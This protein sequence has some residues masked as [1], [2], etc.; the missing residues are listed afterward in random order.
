MEL[1]EITAQ[2]Y[3][4]EVC[5]RG[6]I[7]CQKKFL[8]LNAPKVD[9]VH[10]YIL[11]DEKKRLAFAIGEKNGEWKAPFSAPFAI[12]IELRGNSD[13]KYYWELFNLLK[14][15]VKSEGGK[16]ID[17]YLPPD[18]YNYSQISKIYNSLLGNGFNITY[19]EVNYSF[20]VDY[21]KRKGYE[22]CIHYNAKKNLKIAERCGLKFI[23]CTSLEEKKQAYDIIRVNRDSKGY[24][25]AMSWEQVFDTINVVEHDFFIIKNGKNGIA[26]AMVFK[27]TPEIAQVVYWGDIPNV[28]KYKSINYMAS[29]LIKYYK[30]RD[31]KII[32]IGPSA[33]NGIPNFGLCNFKEGIGCNISNKF[34]FLYQIK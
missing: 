20:D 14:K 33:P 15:K 10:Y 3:E 7:F 4:K 6:P 34:R 12:P 30:N 19:Q 27:V 31:V 22:K 18:I 21:I 8:D 32:D 5:N 25:L 2:D 13:L 11:R 29:E 23:Q 16:S 17:L 9:R 28:S 1:D 24:Y 26:A